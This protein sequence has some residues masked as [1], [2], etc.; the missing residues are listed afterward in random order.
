MGVVRTA[1]PVAILTALVAVAVA[2][3]LSPGQS[4]LGAM[5]AS[6]DADNGSIEILLTVL[7]DDNH[8]IWAGSVAVENRDASVLDALLTASADA[9]LQVEVHQ[10]AGFGPC[11]SYVAEMAGLREKRDGTGWE[12]YTRQAAGNAT[13]AATPWRWADRSAACMPVEAGME[14]RWVWRP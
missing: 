12:Y 8:T 11:G 3:L 9:S 1:V 5:P 2:L 7:G 13:A 14:V 6:D 10:L 4:S